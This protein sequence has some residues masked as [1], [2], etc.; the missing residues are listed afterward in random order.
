LLVNGNELWIGTYEHGLDIMDLRTEKIIRH[1]SS[2]D[3]AGQL[4]SNF[5]VNIYR[6]RA[7][8]ILLG[9]A[10]GLYRYNAK[11]DNFSLITAIDPSYFVYGIL[12]DHAGNIWVATLGNG[13]SYYNP[14]TGDKGSF[15]YHHNDSESISSNAL[16]SIFEDNSHQLWFTTEDGGLNKYMP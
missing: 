6:T 2:G 9:T 5:I 3:G 13:V 11:G 16:T 1:Y 8:D 10:M 4:K 12:E 14:V 15:T 7:G